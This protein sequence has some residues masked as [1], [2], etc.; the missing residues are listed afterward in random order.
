MYTPDKIDRDFCV[1]CREVVE[2]ELKREIVEREIRGKKYAFCMTTA[3]CKKCGV[4]MGVSGHDGT[5]ARII[6]RNQGGFYMENY[7]V[8]KEDF[9]WILKSF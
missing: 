9:S 2:Y 3:Y 7:I 4:K 8:E 5:C 1:E 6:P